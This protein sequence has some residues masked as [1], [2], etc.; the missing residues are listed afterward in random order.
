[1]TTVRTQALL[2]YWQR[3]SAMVLAVCVIVHLVGIIYAVRGGL[4]AAEIL[5][6]TRGS[7]AFAAFYGAF[8]IACAI[9]APIGLANVLAEMR[10]KPGSPPIAQKT[11]QQGG[12]HSGQQMSQHIVIA[13][14]FAVLILVLGLRA[15]YAV[16]AP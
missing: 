9:H 6:R 14:V 3:I 8:V 11:G 1:M 7:W 15:V 16:V 5:A 4:S 12:E 2:W 13:Q 10:R